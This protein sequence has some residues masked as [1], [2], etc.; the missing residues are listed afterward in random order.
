MLTVLFIVL[1]IGYIQKLC[2]VIAQEKYFLTG[3]ELLFLC[4]FAAYI[5]IHVAF[6]RLILIHVFGHELTHAVMAIL[7]GGK[8]REIYVSGRKGGF[9][10]FTKGNALVYLAPYFLPLYAILLTVL[11]KLS[12]SEYRKIFLVLIGFSISFHILMTI[13]SIKQGQ[14]D[15]KE[16]GVIY[17]L[18]LILMM[19]SM[20]L[21]ALLG[22]LFSSVNIYGYMW[23]GLTNS[24]WLIVEAWKWTGNIINGNV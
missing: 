11:L 4:G 5:P 2:Q 19:N 15:L 20:I 21:G 23:G 12:K 13:Y 3:D 6:R 7:S 10:T 24:Y 18:G 17:S 8:V 1:A 16:Q 9:T 14:S 22:L